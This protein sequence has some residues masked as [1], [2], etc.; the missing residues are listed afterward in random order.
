MLSRIFK[1]GIKIV[2]LQILLKINAFLTFLGYSK[3]LPILISSLD[4]CSFKLENL[5]FPDTPLEEWR[6]IDEK[7][8]EMKL[9]LD[10]LL[11]LT[12]IVPQHIDVDSIS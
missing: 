9:Q 5:E 3:I 7:I 4:F 8:N 11:N 12:G 6:E 2:V 1:F 10:L